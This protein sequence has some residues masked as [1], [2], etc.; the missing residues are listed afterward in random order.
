MPIARKPLRIMPRAEA[1]VQ[2]RDDVPHR[3][4][5]AISI[6]PSGHGEEIPRRARYL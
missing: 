6:W 5:Q 3:T 1:A 2:P 4:V